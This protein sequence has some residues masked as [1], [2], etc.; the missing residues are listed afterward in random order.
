[1]FK[2]SQ[3]LK[4]LVEYCTELLTNDE[5]EEDFKEDLKMKRMIHNIRMK[6]S[7]ED[8]PDL[9]P[10]MFANVLKKLKKGRRKI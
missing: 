4:A 3:I 8:D 1:M 10:S 6:D 2:P 7:Y 9:T 5:P